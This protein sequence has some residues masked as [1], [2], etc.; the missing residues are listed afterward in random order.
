MYEVS[1]LIASYNRPD[2]LLKALGS[3]KP[4]FGGSFE[5]I[6][7]DDLSPRSPEIRTLLHSF[8]SESGLRFVTHGQNVGMVENWKSL[9]QL[10]RGRYVYFLGDDDL[11]DCGA[12][13][14][15]S[16]IL[17][18]S[19][20]DVLLTG[21]SMIDEDDALR[22]QH[23][24]RSLRQIGG[25]CLPDSLL[26]NDFSVFLR[27]A[28]SFSMFVRR[29]L[30]ETFNYEA[31]VGIGA[32]RHFLYRLVLSGHVCLV[33]KEKVL[34]WRVPSS[35]HGQYKSQSSNRYETLR[36]NCLVAQSILSNHSTER[37]LGFGF[38]KDRLPQVIGLSYEELCSVNFAD[39]Q[40]PVQFDLLKKADKRLLAF[41]SR[42]RRAFKYLYIRFL[43]FVLPND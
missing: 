34:H 13:L 30:Y 1:I 5:V 12:F 29:D 19:I 17:R 4:L 20:P 40:D 2:L 41:P 27:F 43:D 33:S 14:R 11:L 7:A 8:G 26:W 3:L 18:D 23:S 16:E 15:A 25:A 24:L 10:A 32:D 31:G 39:S 42:L 22:S 38:E 28:H 21:Y 35:K 6:V 36:S 37:L 9:I